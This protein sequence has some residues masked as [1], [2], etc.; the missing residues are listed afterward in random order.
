M[1][2][3]PMQHAVGPECR[4]LCPARM[5]LWEIWNPWSKPGMMQPL[6]GLESERFRATTA[7]SQSIGFRCPIP[8]IRLFH[9]TFIA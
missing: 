1:V 2:M 7:T 8:I 3:P 5:L 9:K 4:T 6:S